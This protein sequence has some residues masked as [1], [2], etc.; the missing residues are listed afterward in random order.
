MKYALAQVAYTEPMKRRLFLTTSAALLAASCG[1]VKPSPTIPQ[2]PD[3][4]TRL[5][6]LKVVMDGVTIVISLLGPKMG[7][8]AEVVAAIKKWLQILSPILIRISNDL[9]QGVTLTRMSDPI[10]ALMNTLVTLPSLVI[11]NEVLSQLLAIVTTGM[12]FIDALPLPGTLPGVNQARIYLEEKEVKALA[13][14]IDIAQ[15]NAKAIES[16]R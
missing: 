15:A 3:L 12:G 9:R 4:E 5:N 1:F 6:R 13:K 8:S 7:N 11:P 16:L 10:V 2:P 14:I